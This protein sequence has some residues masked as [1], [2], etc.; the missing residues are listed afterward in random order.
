MNIDKVL[1]LKNWAIIGA[2]D[3]KNSFGYKIPVLLKERGYKTCCINPNKKYIDSIKTV[4]SIL[5]CGEIDV[6]NMIVNPNI[7]YKLIDDIKL[8]D[9]KYL[10]FQ[11]GSY[12]NKVIEKCKKLDINYII[13]KC[14]YMEIINDN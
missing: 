4:D 10:F 13:G 2:T 12:D 3:D 1:K 8:K 9:I 14:V 7:A 6:V 11:P 5:K